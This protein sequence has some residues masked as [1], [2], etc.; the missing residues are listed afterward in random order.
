M[1]SR[2]EVSGTL[3]YFEDSVGNTD[4]DD[5]IP[6]TPTTPITKPGDLYELESVVK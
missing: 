3:S 6:D 1:L 5:S 2:L 4:G